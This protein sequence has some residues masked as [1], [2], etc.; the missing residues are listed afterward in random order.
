MY[1]RDDFCCKLS[2]IGFH[3]FRFNFKHSFCWFLRMTSFRQQETMIANV[4]AKRK[5]A[6]I[7]WLAWFSERPIF[8]KVLS[9]DWTVHK[10]WVVACLL[11]NYHLYEG[12]CRLCFFA[13]GFSE[14]PC[15]LR[16]Q[17]SCQAPC[18]RDHHRRMSLLVRSMS[19]KGSLKGVRWSYPYVVFCVATN[20]FCSE[21]GFSWKCRFATASLLAGSQKGKR[22][23][24]GL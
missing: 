8:L 14:V 23:C 16:G 17:C 18:R 21:N 12:L 10:L 15:F 3:S 7:L 19:F 24:N 13:S 22:R 9:K 4:V 1:F 5:H 11:Q 2:I 6:E 20:F